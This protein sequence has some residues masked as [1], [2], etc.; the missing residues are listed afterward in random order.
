VTLD[1]DLYTFGLAEAGQLGLGIV[2]SPDAAEQTALGPGGSPTRSPARASPARVVPTASACRVGPDGTE[3]VQV[4]C[5]SQHTVA[6]DA[7][8]NVFAAGLNADGQLGLGHRDAAS[9]FARVRV[10]ATNADG[11]VPE[12]PV[13][14]VACGDHHTMFLTSRGRVYACGNN[15]YYQVGGPGGKLFFY[16]KISFFFLIG[17]RFHLAS[18]TIIQPSPSTDTEAVLVPILVNTGGAR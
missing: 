14:A 11:D 7:A 3:I 17:F 2:A 1:G 12:D 13:V 8:G 18:R 6:L 9:V 16:K 10:G 4:A 15:N 5:G